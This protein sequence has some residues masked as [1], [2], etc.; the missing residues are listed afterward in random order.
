MTHQECL[1][2]SW[3]ILLKKTKV[4]PP[5]DATMV[6]FQHVDGCCNS[7]VGLDQKSPNWS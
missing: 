4:I 5:E 2:F 7:K 6:C 1:L 3:E